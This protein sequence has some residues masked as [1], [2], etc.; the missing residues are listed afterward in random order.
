MYGSASWYLSSKE[1]PWFLCKLA[2][3]S[4]QRPSSFTYKVVRGVW[5]VLGWP[6]SNPKNI[7]CCQ[8]W[9]NSLSHLSRAYHAPGLFHVHYI[10]SVLITLQ[11]GIGAIIIPLLLI[12]KWSY[13]E[14]RILTWDHMTGRWRAQQTFW[15]GMALK[16]VQWIKSSEWI[17][18]SCLT[19]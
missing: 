10:Y 3:F 15:K 2:E 7:L 17:L 11:W 13:R 5:W 6:L 14:D 8:T 19:L 12:G 1:T 4:A 18:F 16:S 9:N